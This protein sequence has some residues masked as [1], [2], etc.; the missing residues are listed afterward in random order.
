MARQS[1]PGAPITG[2]DLLLGH[3]PLTRKWILAHFTIKGRVK[4]A[5]CLIRWRRMLSSFLHHAGWWPLFIL[6]AKE[7]VAGR[8]GGRGR[9]TLGGLL[10]KNLPQDLSTLQRSRPRLFG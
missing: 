7:S 5:G 2:P 4:R 1:S 6:V 3:W 10:V 8:P 9:A